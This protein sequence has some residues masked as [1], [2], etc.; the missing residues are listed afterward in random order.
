MK[1]LEQVEA[2][3]KTL[4]DRSY[5]RELTEAEVQEYLHLDAMLNEAKAARKVLDAD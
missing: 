5:E 4:L 2:E 1:T 3:W